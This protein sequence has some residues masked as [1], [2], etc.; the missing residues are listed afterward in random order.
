MV[1]YGILVTL[2]LCLFIVQT[3]G[4]FYQIVAEGLFIGLAIWLV[5][6]EPQ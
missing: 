1:V 6:I 2:L 3:T 4:V 5:G